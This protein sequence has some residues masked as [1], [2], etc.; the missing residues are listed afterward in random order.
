MGLITGRNPGIQIRGSR[1][2]VI[3]PNH[4]AWTSVSTCCSAAPADDQTIVVNTKR[5]RGQTRARTARENPK[6]SPALVFE[7]IGI[8]V[9]RTLLT[10]R[11]CAVPADFTKA[12]DCVRTAGANF[13]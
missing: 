6:N 8:L 2:L 7:I 4:G 5:Q 13:I 11:T 3:F 10:E 9:S 12:I 1:D